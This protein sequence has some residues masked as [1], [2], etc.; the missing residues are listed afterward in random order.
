M[1]QKLV[2]LA[3]MGLLILLLAFVPASAQSQDEARQTEKV[4]Q[5]I[6]KLG[7]G[8]KARVEI[9][10]K[11][12]RKLQGHVTEITD[13]HFVIIDS[14]TGAATTVLYSQVQHI[15]INRHPH[16][17]A[18][19]LAFVGGLVGLGLILAVALRGS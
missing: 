12:N 18:I 17:L 5:T 13:D 19:G 14:K 10:L 6:L 7:T 16:Q 4:K 1:F 9:A 3:L 8:A 2:S 11:D 15:R